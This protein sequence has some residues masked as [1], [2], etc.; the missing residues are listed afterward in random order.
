[1][2]TTL[3][4]ALSL[5]LKEKSTQLKSHIII[6]EKTSNYIIDIVTNICGETKTIFLLNQA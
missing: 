4:V 5:P 6:K 1:M 3:L 2:T